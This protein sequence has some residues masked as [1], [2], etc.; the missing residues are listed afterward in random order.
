[1]QGIVKVRGRYAFAV[2]DKEY[3]LPSRFK[4]KDGETVEFTPR[5]RKARE[6]KRIVTEREITS[7]PTDSCRDNA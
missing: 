4:G 2:A 1:M 6:V 5:G 7:I 3:L